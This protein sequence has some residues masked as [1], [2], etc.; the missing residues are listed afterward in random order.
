[1]LVVNEMVKVVSITVLL[2]L[3]ALPLA[4]PLLARTFCTCC[5]NAE[6][7]LTVRATGGCCGTS[8]IPDTTIPAHQAMALQLAA[9][10]GHQPAR[11]CDDGGIGAD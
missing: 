7:E 8:A 4:G 11:S 5:A 2:T 10:G 9:P 6:C 1:M 3:L